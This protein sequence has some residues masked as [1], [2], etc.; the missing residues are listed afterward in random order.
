MY[1]NFILGCIS[2]SEK[3]SDLFVEQSENSTEEDDNPPNNSSENNSADSSIPDTDTSSDTGL[4]AD[5]C[6]EA[7]LL[8]LDQSSFTPIA[9]IWRYD[10]N[11]RELELL[12]TLDCPFQAGDYPVAM[13]ANHKGELWLSSR[14]GFLFQ[15]LPSVLYCTGGQYNIDTPEY[16]VGSLAFVRSDDGSQEMLYFSMVEMPY[17]SS[18]AGAIGLFSP[19]STTFIGETGLLGYD[20]F[21]DLAGTGDGQLYGLRPEGSTSALVSISTSTAAILNEW[22]I[23]VAAPQGWS[24][25]FLNQN[26]WLFTSDNGTTTDVHFFNPSTNQLD[27]IETFNFQV[28]GAA[29]P[30]CAPEG[31]GS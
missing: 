11:D 12:T 23:N 20:S 17:T 27:F 8:E 22:S 2:L 3:E 9:K 29:L 14:D 16:D 25:V 1:F 6:D 7:H 31:S 24:L 5:H 10:I 30:T 15:F 4:A 28:V 18:S 19:P 13:T 21:I 26:F